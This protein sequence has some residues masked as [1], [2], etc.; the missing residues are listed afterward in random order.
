MARLGSTLLRFESL[1]ST[2]DLARELAVKGQD[3]GVAVLAETQTAGRGRMGRS[4]LSP[5]GGGLYL[6]IILRPSIEPYKGPVITLA[7]AVAVAETL[8]LDFAVDADIKW[9]NDVLVG[10]GSISR[11]AASLMNSARSLHPSCWRRG[12]WFLSMS[13]SL[14]CSIGSRAGTDSRWSILIK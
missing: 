2:N 9:P 6:S 5:S 3:E 8:I 4:W 7:A 13:F 1:S 12:V 11:S 14:R 10:S